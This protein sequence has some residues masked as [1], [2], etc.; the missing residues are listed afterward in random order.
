MFAPNPTPIDAATLRAS[1][2]PARDCSKRD[3]TWVLA[4]TILG[5]SMAFI[6]TTVVNVGLPA[7]QASLAA[8]VSGAQWI[9]NA[10][11]LMLGAL[12][13][14]GGAAGDRFGRRRICILGISVFTAG[15]GACGLA[16]NVWVL[17]GARALQGM[18]G[19]LLV[20]ASLAI[21]SASFPEKE[22]GRA[23]GTWAGASALTTALGP[24][25]GGWLVDTWSWRTIF[26]INVPIGVL[27]LLLMV[28]RV[29]ESRDE[30]GSSVDWRG[31]VLAVAALGLL[32]YGFTAAS[33]AGW[34]QLS[35]FGSLAGGFCMLLLLLWWEAR[36][37]SPM[38]PLI[39]FHSATFS[40]ANA[41]TLLL[42]FALSGAL[43]FVPYDLIEIHGYSATQ[44]GAAF[45][46]FSL[47]M[48]GL[49]RWSGGLI[50]R[51]GAQVPLTVGPA[52][53]AAGLGLLAVPTTAGSYWTTFFPAMMI[54]GLG[55]AVTVA[56]LTTAVLH[57]AG[58][59]YAGAASGIN[60]AVARIAG[61]LAVALLGAVAV[62]AF[63]MALDERLER[64]HVPAAIS[65]ALQDQ[66]QRLAEARAPP[67]LDDATR[68]AAQQVLRE[69]FVFSFRVTT[70]IA[71]AAA[72]LSAAIAW[73]T[74]DRLVP[75][76]ARSL[77]KIHQ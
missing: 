72:L 16:A 57:S 60:N 47:T 11:T 36:S 69:S 1:A 75:G 13:L 76:D 25:L 31:G 2:V 17:I 28:R 18:G 24:V 71:A 33:L 53:A 74:I 63:R 56:P 68:Q 70:L 15:S 8:G 39:L 9:V 35:V 20:P 5:S 6:D 10:Y 27:A 73:L 30:A 58:D 50:G 19:A 38:V 45:L 34:A 3:Q 21:I 54:L 12:I 65:Q 66:V 43:F 40:G 48:A 26:F 41:I 44:A 23:I 51:Y 22:R 61:M 29:P 32:A 49:S 42:Y 62:G 55:M 52:V 7:M 64:L 46:P 4:A 14:V 77:V 67:Q 59:R 37:V